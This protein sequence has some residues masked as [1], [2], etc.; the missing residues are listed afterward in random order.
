MANPHT[1]S[2]HKHHSN[3]LGQ[4]QPN[5]IVTHSFYFILIINVKLMSIQKIIN[6]TNLTDNHFVN[7]RQTHKSLNPRMVQ[8]IT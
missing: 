1:N 7:L 3:P 4:N 6:P 2:N 8:P 5:L